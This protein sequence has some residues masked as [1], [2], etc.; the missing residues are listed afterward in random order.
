MFRLTRDPIDGA[1]WQALLSDPGCGA[2][3][4]FEGRVRNHHQGR[5]VKSLEYEAY[6][7][8]ALQE[9]KR[10]LESVRHEYGL[11]GILCV[12]RTGRLG[13]GETAIWLG[14][15]SAHREEAFAAV[16]AAMNAIKTSVPIWKREHYLDGEPA[17]VLCREPGH[18]QGGP[19]SQGEPH[20]H[21]HP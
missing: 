15:A 5:Q 21:P 1:A 11:Q 20:T 10:I 13:I 17:W 6:E 12:H 3:V 14:A 19:P 2:F 4:C 18:A 16:A 9:G 8:L 7:R